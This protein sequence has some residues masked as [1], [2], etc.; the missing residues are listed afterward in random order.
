[1]PPPSTAHSLPPRFL[2]APECLKPLDRI[3]VFFLCNM[4]LRQ[5]RRHSVAG[6]RTDC[7][8]CDVSPTMWP[9]V[10]LSHCFPAASICLTPSR[11]TTS[12]HLSN[13]CCL[14]P[15]Q[16]VLL[17]GRSFKEAVVGWLM[18]KSPLVSC[19]LTTLRLSLHVLP[20]DFKQEAWIIGGAVSKRTPVPVRGCRHTVYS[21]HQICCRRSG[22]FLFSPFFSPQCHQQFG[23][24]AAT[25]GCTASLFSESYL[26]D[27]AKNWNE[28]QTK[29]ISKG[30]DWR[31]L[32]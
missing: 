29:S 3:G 31:S 10:P 26:A 7:A 14:N 28:C 2:S 16:D 23:V 25:A 5:R 22:A 12:K 24:A 32:I 11:T 20:A 1:M 9:S 4:E 27:D 15:Q 30:H 6:H 21:S 17:F 8:R 13:R 19:Q 18:A